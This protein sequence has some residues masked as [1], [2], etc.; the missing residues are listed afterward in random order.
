MNVALLDQLDDPQAD[1]LKGG[2]WDLASELSRRG[3]TPRVIRFQAGQLGVL[4]MPRG[5]AIGDL[6]GFHPDL[7]PDSPAMRETLTEYLGRVAFRHELA[8]LHTFDERLIP[9]LKATRKKTHFQLLGP[10]DD[11]RGAPEERAR[12]LA[13]R[14]LRPA[15]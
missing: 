4:T 13:E 3:L 7:P 1:W 9:L 15:P 11:P 6:V 5:G 14:Y 10:S 2:I 12:I 8:V